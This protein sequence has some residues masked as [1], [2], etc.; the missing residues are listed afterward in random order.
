[1]QLMEAFAAVILGAPHR[2]HDNAAQ[3]LDD[4]PSRI[5]APDH[6]PNIYMALG[7]M[8]V[9][10]RLWAE[11]HGVR[12]SDRW[13]AHGPAARGEGYPARHQFLFALFRLIDPDPDHMELTH[14]AKAA[15]RFHR[16]V[17]LFSD[18]G[19]EAL[20]D[21]AGV[22]VREAAGSSQLNADAARRLTM[23]EGIRGLTDDARERLHRRSA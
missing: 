17:T 1:R 10:G 5:F 9:A 12:W 13:Q 15:E 11:R 8:V 4:V 14:S 18:R 7:W 23:T 21:L 6:E 20:T 2:V 3:F 16:I 22:I 19:A